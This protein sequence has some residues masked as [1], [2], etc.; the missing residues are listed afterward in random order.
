MSIAVRVCKLSTAHAV[1]QKFPSSPWGCGC[2]SS[3]I[4]TYLNRFKGYDCGLTETNV[5]FI[6]P[7]VKPT[8]DR[9]HLW[10]EA[11]YY[12][13]IFKLGVDF[14][15]LLNGNL[16][17]DVQCASYVIERWIRDTP[18]FQPTTQGWKNSTWTRMNPS[19]LSIRPVVHHLPTYLRIILCNGIELCEA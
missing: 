14:E 4:L 11:F 9:F 10:C 6:Q 17:N 19:P 18:R 5:I 2:P 1:I 13:I 7:L 16:L 15:C 3:Y 12:L 8:P